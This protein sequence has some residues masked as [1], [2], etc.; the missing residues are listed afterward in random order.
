MKGGIMKTWYMEME[1]E[2]KENFRFVVRLVT[3]VLSAV[4]LGCLFIIL[5]FAF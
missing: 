4:M 3:T 2:E 1:A 5:L